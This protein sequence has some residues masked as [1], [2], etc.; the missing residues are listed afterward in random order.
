MNQK[1]VRR[2]FKSL[3]SGAKTSLKQKRSHGLKEGNILWFYLHNKLL[4]KK[5]LKF[6]FW[7]KV[8]TPKRSQKFDFIKEVKVLK[9]IGPQKRK[10]IMVVIDC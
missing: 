8:L 9:P 2:F 6:G 7:L 1:N 4:M 10:Q 5:W 3:I